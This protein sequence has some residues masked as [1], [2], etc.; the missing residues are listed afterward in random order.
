MLLSAWKARSDMFISV[1]VVTWYWDPVNELVGV[2]VTT[3]LFCGQ[4]TVEENESKTTFSQGSIRLRRIARAKRFRV[5]DGD[6]CWGK[7]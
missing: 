6:E 7:S 2:G 4:R 5:E 1:Y 3:R